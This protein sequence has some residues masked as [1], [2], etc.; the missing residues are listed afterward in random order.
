[1]MVSPPP[2]SDNL[3]GLLALLS[4]PAA[5]EKRVAE[6]R[7]IEAAAKARIAESE[8][9]AADAA[10][11]LADLDEA[12]RA[13]A[14]ALETLAKERAEVNGKLAKNA[15]DRKALDAGFAS[16]DE[17]L[18]EFAAKADAFEKRAAEREADLAVRS[19]DLL[20]RETQASAIIKGYEDKIA[21]LREIVG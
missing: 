2:G 11:K 6:L 7:E 5:T 14:V 19:N 16:L 18:A 20:V 13:N 9:V 8:A 10:K 1:M 15:E 12:F 4:D 3:T 21:K 17:Q